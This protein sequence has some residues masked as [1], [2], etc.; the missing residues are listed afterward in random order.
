MVTHHPS[1]CPIESTHERYDEARYFFGRMLATYHIPDEFRFNLNAFIQALRNITFMLQSEENKPPDFEDW[2]GVKQQTMRS[3]DVLR[4]FVQ[5]R[6]IVV[7]QSSLAA[8][9]TASSGVFRGRRLK[10]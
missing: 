7:K 6:N 5:A 3:D 1:V 10:L 4:R 9:S 2:Y 8:K